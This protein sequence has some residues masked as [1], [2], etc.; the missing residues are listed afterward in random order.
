MK[1]ILLASYTL[2]LFTFPFL[3]HAQGT[4]Q[5][6]LSNIPVFLGNVVIPFLFGIAFLIFIIN[7]VRYFIFE[8]NNEQGQEKAKSLIIYSTAA[9]VFLLIFFGIVKLFVDT[10]GLQ[11]QAPPCSDYIKKTDPSKCP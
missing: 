5:S 6:L 11:N 4:L 7:V 8:S 1:K 3:T 9:F 2:L 10:T